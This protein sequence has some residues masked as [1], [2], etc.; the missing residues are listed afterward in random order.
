MEKREERLFQNDAVN[1]AGKITK[2]L[3]DKEI[4]KGLSVGHIVT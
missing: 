1:C 4:L 2:S 3:Y